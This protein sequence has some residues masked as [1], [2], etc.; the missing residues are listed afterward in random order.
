MEKEIDTHLQFQTTNPTTS[1]MPNQILRII[2]L[3]PNRKASG[4]DNTQ[5]IDVRIFPLSAVTYLAKVTSIAFRFPYFTETRKEANV[6][7]PPKSDKIPVFPQDKCP[8][9]LLDRT[10]KAVERQF[11]SINKYIQYYHAKS[12]MKNLLSYQDETRRQN[13]CVSPNKRL[14]TSLKEHTAAIFLGLFKAH[15]TLNAARIQ[16]FMVLLPLSFHA[17]RKFREDI[18]E[19]GKQYK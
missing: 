6:I 3:L 8:I 11:T 9:M 19:N 16:D 10:G 2:K 17:C 15:D 4:H 1:I 18:F 7:S 14:I 13:Y 5:S 12:Q